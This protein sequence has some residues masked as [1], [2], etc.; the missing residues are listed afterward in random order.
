MKKINRIFFQ[1]LALAI[2]LSSAVSNA[3]AQGGCISAYMVH[4]E[5]CSPG[6]D[7]VA[8]VDLP[9][10]LNSKSTI[11]WKKSG[12]I[13]STSAIA[14][15]LTSGTYSVTVKSSACPSM[16]FYTGSVTVTKNP[17]C[18]VTVQITGP[19]SVQGDCNGIPEVTFVANAS[20]GTPPYT[21][22]GGWEQN[23]NVAF[24]TFSPGEGHFSVVCIAH[25]SE[26]NYGWDGVTC[27]SIHWRRTR[28][29]APPGQLRNHQ[30]LRIFVGCLDF[31]H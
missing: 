10:G 4:E 14:S 3:F 9:A 16:V 21:F 25:D 7:G 24:K 27:A 20:G 1:I 5:S 13:V 31:H 18:Q 11:E 29:S 8:V 26:G 6:H 23:G 12:E 19:T 15:G 30:Y 22:S 2:V 17:D 28:R